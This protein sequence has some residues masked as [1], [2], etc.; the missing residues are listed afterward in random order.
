M[1]DA[2]CITEPLHGSGAAPEITEFV[3]AVQVGRI[4]DDMIMKRILSRNILSIEKSCAFPFNNNLPGLLGC[5]YT[6]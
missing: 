1:F 4:P 3:C 6:S 5:V 2:Q